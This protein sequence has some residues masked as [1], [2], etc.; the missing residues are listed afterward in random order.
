M[1][2]V[3][4]G[5]LAVAATAFVLQPLFSTR[6]EAAAPTP[7]TRT[8]RERLRLHEKREQLLLGLS[9]LDF[10]HDAG[11]LAEAEHRELREKLLADAARVT[12]RLDE[13]DRR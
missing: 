1:T 4:L 10:E 13:L 6:R 7:E 12:A 2:S 8:D 3:L 11:K 9:E 5:A